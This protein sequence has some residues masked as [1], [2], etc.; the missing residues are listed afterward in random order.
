MQKSKLYIGPISG[1]AYLAEAVHIRRMIFS[2][3]VPCFRDMSPEKLIPIMQNEDCILDCEF[4]RD[5]ISSC[6]ALYTKMRCLPKTCS[7]TFSKDAV[8]TNLENLLR[9]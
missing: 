9:S 8:K 4:S 3:S 2:S 7:G 5:G 1:M 6:Q